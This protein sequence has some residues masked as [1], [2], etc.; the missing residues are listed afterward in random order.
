MA[1]VESIPEKNQTPSAQK[2]VLDYCM[3]PSKIFDEDEQ[4]AY[5]S[6]YNC[7]PELANESFLATQKIYG[8]ELDGVRFYHFVQ[9]FKIGE[10]ISPQEANE[11]GMEL[12]RGFQKFKNHEAIVAT[13]IDKD[14]LHNHIVVCAYDLESGLKL[15]YNKFFL[16]DLR[17]KSDE[18]CQAHGLN[19]LKKYNPNVKSQRLGPKEYRAAMN[20]NS[21]K[22]GLRSTIDFCM[23]R[24][25]SKDELQSLMKKYGYDMVW[26]PERKY[27]TYICP[28]S[29]GKERRVRDI[30]LNDEKYLKENMEHEFR[31][32]TELYGQAQ[33]KNIPPMIQ[34][35]LL[36][37]QTEQ[38]IPMVQIS[39]EEWMKLTEAVR[40]ME[41]LS[42][43]LSAQKAI[44]SSEASRY[45][46]KMMKAAEVQKEA[47]EAALNKVTKEA[48]EQ[49]GKAS[50]K[51]AEVIDRRIRR[52]EALWWLRLALTAVPMLLVL[53]LWARVGLGI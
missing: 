18:I 37:E 51:A 21:W 15:H 22:M 13:H 31:I 48:T 34:E 52:D 23:A 35:E 24:A 26:T 36:E 43:E 49:V 44:L 50:E 53:L 10:A 29:D 45:T 4:L 9:S 11:I 32:R 12:V 8:H 41:A 28:T 25:G 3:Q 39:T 1:V 47:T 30:K 17:Q 7:I 20:G 46:E 16:S 33:G 40:R 2:G 27:I 38:E 14:H 6:G 5:I 19:V 42:A